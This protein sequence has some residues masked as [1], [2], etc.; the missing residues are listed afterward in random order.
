MAE[1]LPDHKSCQVNTSGL[2]RG[3]WHVERV[4]L[5]LAFSTNG[6]LK[7]NSFMSQKFSSRI[8]ILEDSSKLQVLRFLTCQR[9]YHVER[10]SSRPIT[11]VKQHWARIVL[12]WE[13]AWELRVPLAFL[14][15]FILIFS[16]S[17]SP[18]F[19]RCLSLSLSLS[20]SLKFLQ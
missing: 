3:L 4:S 17:L 14:F 11:E 12:G 16:L 20:L 15:Y 13:T 5:A 1:T 6:L 7:E 19:C 2:P 9:P 8:S 18:C 10:T